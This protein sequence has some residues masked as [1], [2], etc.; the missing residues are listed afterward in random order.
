VVDFYGENVASH[1]WPSD[2]GVPMTLLDAAGWAAA[3]RKAGLKVLEQGRL[4]TPP[5]KASAPWKHLEGSLLTL[6]GSA[7]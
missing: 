1:S 4:K 6:G 5:E 2:V 3:F 7:A